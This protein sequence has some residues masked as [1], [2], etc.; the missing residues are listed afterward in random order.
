MLR[1]EWTKINVAFVS[2]FDLNYKAEND[3]FVQISWLVTHFA[4]HHCKNSCS[5]QNVIVGQQLQWV[6][7]K[8][9]FLPSIIYFHDI[10]N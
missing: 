1:Y 2:G 4:Y 5:K 10:S 6:A 7:T 8:R 3:T 9:L